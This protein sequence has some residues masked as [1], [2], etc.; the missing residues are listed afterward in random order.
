MDGGRMFELAE[1][2]AIAKSRQDIPA[3]LEVLHPDM[4]LET[5]AF[6]TRAQGLVENERILARFF[7]SFPD[8]HVTL[9]GHADSDGTLVCWGTARMTMT[10]DRFGVVPNGRRAELSVFITFA[11]RD[12]RIAHERFVFDLSELCAQSGVSTDAVRRRLFGD[13]S[14]AA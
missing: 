10:G 5:P 12:D 4:V 8:Y 3:A 7:T 9:D 13:A 2:L 11:F 14:Q 6:G 1:R